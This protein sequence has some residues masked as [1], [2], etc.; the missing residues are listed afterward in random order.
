[1]ISY[2]E[3]IKH[4]ISIQDIQGKLKDNEYKD[5]LE[6]KRDLDLM[7][8]N[9]ENFFGLKSEIGKIVKCL[10]NDFEIAIQS[11]LITEE[12]E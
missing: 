3:V 1:M 8:N 4:H 9:I 11:S 6:F 10:K 12:E 2:K 7:W 5:F